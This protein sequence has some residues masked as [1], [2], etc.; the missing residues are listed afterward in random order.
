MKRFHNIDARCPS[1][2]GIS[3]AC[4]KWRTNLC[5]SY[6][7]EA[8]ENEEGEEEE[9]EEEEE[10]EEEERRCRRCRREKKRRRYAG[11]TNAAKDAH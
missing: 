6:Q 4:H 1:R 3:K 5:Q 7:T 11:D 10:E 2:R 9:K 8:E